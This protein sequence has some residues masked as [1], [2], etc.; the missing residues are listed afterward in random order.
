M[1]FPFILCIF[2]LAGATSSAG[3][4]PQFR[5]PGAASLASDA[6]P[7]VAWSETENTAWRIDLPGRGPSSPIVVRDRV[8]VTATSGFRHDRLHVLCFAAADGKP[9]WE[10]QFW[11]TGRTATH[12]SISGAAPTP[13]SDG[14]H[15]FAFFS[16]ND[17]FCLDL[18]GNLVWYRGLGYDY[19]KAGSDVGMA[20]SPL[21]ADGVVVVQLENQSDSFAAGLDAAT[22]E[23]R[24]RVERPARSSWT[25]PI[26]LP[27]AG[28]RKSAVLLQ[29][30]SYVTAHDVQTG[31]ELWRFSEPVAGISSSVFCNGWLLVPMRGLTALRFS[32][33][34]NA[35]EIVW[36]ANR[37]RP[38]SSSPLIHDGRVYV[39]SNANVRCGDAKTGELLWFVRLKGTHWATPVLAGGHLYCVNQDGDMQVV[40]VGDKEGE[41]V[42]ENRFG[43]TIHA[44]PAVAGDALYVRSDKH[45]WKIAK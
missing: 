31:D 19:P 29:S 24:W 26:A 1:K 12:S 34:S 28:R 9:L 14:Q 22:G 16:S 42:A 21:V 44:T 41:V 27:G 23:T 20:S 40:R 35:P 6:Q 45:L 43:E 37:M 33:E 10:R 25:S 38:G 17:L 15:V 5:G 32:E 18:D 39:I 4:W 8:L 3:D 7:P 36:D 30:T 2:L 11:A 13:A